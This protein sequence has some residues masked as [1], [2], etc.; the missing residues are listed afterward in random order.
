MVFIKCAQLVCSLAV[1]LMAAILA[2]PKVMHDPVI[3]VPVASDLNGTSVLLT[4]GNSGVGLETARSLARSGARVI[5]TSRSEKRAVEK[6]ASFGGE[7][8]ALDLSDLAAVRVFAEQIRRRFETS[9]LDVLV[10]N[11]GMTYPD[12]YSGPYLTAEGKD[13]MMA[14]NY[15]GH[16]LLVHVLRPV[17]ERSKTRIVI[18]SSI[19]HWF[20]DQGMATP[21]FPLAKDGEPMGPITAFRWY[22]ASKLQ[23][24]LFAFKLQRELEGTGVTTTVCTPGVVKTKFSAIDR[25][26]DHAGKLGDLPFAQSVEEGAKPIVASVVVPTVPLG[27]MITPYWIWE[28]LASALPVPVR[29][30]LV[31][32]FEVSQKLVWGPIRA[33][34]TSPES[35]DR[36]LQ[37]ALWAWTAAHVGV[38]LADNK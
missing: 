38:T 25:H 1:L 34:G 17:L 5:I 10:L 28:E 29:S 31:L 21:N 26:Q 12:D 36:A 3:Q 9:R 24:A 22:G 20:A 16:W 18:V 30:L 32:T 4:G 19:C 13:H 37:D 33:H 35:Q 23:G 2:L 27:K 6:A 15:L 8:L 7:G 11:A 14:S